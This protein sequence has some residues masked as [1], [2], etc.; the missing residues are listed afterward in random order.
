MNELEFEPT[1][2]PFELVL[3]LLAVALGTFA[4][5][6][7]LP[8]WQPALSE[9]L[10]GPAPK[11]YWFL[12][13]AAGLV[14]Y[15]VLGLSVAIGLIISNKL[16]RLWNGG[17]TAVDLHQF[18]S[19]LA[20]ALTIFHALILLGDQYIK[21]TVPQV[22]TPFGYI[23]YR[24][25]WVGVGQI[26]FYVTVIVAASFYFRKRIGYR[27]WRTLH[28]VSFI[29]FLAVTLHGIFAGTDSEQLMVVYA[30]SAFVIYFLLL[31]RIFEKVKTPAPRPHALPVKPVRNNS[32]E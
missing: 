21:S 7:I 11:A 31:Y 6:V 24:P 27:T 1:I 29:T 4:A 32:T 14:A 28:Y 30:G 13:R 10:V 15:L 3:L 12:A 5:A 16:A 18:A 25:E 17:P 8:T 19:W 26:A 20:I 2:N 22:L 9:S 23:N